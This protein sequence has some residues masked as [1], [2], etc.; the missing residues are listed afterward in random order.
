MPGSVPVVKL[1]RPFLRHVPTAQQIERLAFYFA[2]FAPV[3]K[4][5]SQLPSE[6]SLGVRIPPGASQIVAW[7]TKR[8][9][10]QI[11]AGGAKSR[12]VKISQRSSEPLLGVRIPPGTLA[13]VIIHRR[14]SN[15]SKANDFAFG[16]GRPGLCG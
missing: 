10:V 5:I 8:F 14:D 1:A 4:W 2:Q 15:G 6:Q 16:W 3:V 7:R 9:Q 11:L 13:S 12:R